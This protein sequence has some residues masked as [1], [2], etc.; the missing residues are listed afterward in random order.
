MPTCKRRPWFTEET[1]VNKRDIVLPD[2]NKNRKV[3]GT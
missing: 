1:N 2:A 3:S